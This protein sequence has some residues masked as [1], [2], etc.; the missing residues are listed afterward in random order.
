MCSRG[1]GYV[2]D[3]YLEPH[4]AGD[5]EYVHV[6]YHAGQELNAGSHLPRQGSGGFAAAG[7]Y[8]GQGSGGYASAAGG[9][10]DRRRRGPQTYDIGL[11]D[12]TK[13]EEEEERPGGGYGKQ[14]H[15][16]YAQPGLYKA[17]GS[18][19]NSHLYSQGAAAARPAVKKQ[20]KQPQQAYAIRGPQAY[21]DTGL[22]GEEGQGGNDEDLGGH[23]GGGNFEEYERLVEE[24][25]RNSI[26]GDEEDGRGSGGEGGVGGGIEDLH[27]LDL[28]DVNGVEIAAA[29]AVE[30][31]IEND[32]RYNNNGF[33]VEDK[34]KN[35]N[36]DIEHGDDDP[37]LNGGGGAGDLFG[38]DNFQAYA[39]H[40]GG[41]GE[42]GFGGEGHQTDDFNG[43]F[44]PQQLGFGGSD[45]AGEGFHN[46]GGK[47]YEE[48]G[49]HPSAQ[50]PVGGAYSQQ[51]PEVPPP[52]YTEPPQQQQQGD[53][54]EEGG[55]RQGQRPDLDYERYFTLHYDYD[56]EPPGN[57]GGGG[58]QQQ[59][60]ERGGHGGAD[61]N[62]FE[63]IF[64]DKRAARGQ[65]PRGFGQF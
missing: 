48:G 19:G 49:F 14:P 45:G 18:A 58:Q 39:D 35:N 55:Q 40:Q 44:G 43:P 4:D 22:E 47:P 61:D 29:A 25:H 15:G 60:D 8:S 1:A 59:G 27:G 17:G 21:Y 7:G 46:G 32:P 11:Q 23:A 26:H 10:G 33:D 56:Y 37:S 12:Y 13:A 52:R 57:N 24:G 30:E 6:G 65:R 31:Q 34:N 28:E 51:H 5:E 16:R 3:N 62:G 63:D 41:G 2:E 9:Y 54:P 53:G 64:A 20:Q 42:P 50:P 38:P 36:N